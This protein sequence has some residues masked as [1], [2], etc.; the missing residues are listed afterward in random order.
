[1]CS[2]DLSPLA[3]NLWM[4]QANLL[5]ALPAL[6]G[7]AASRP[8]LRG[9]GIGAAA[10]AKMSPGLLVLGLVRERAWGAVLAAG[11]AVVGLGVLTLPLVGPAAQLRFWGE[12]LPGFL[13]GEYHGLHIGIALPGNH[14]LADWFNR[15][16]PGELPTRL[17]D[18]ARLAN[19]LA[20][21]G[22]VGAWALLFRRPAAPAAST[23]PTAA[24]TPTASGCAT[25]AADPDAPLPWA[26]LVVLMVLLPVYTFEHHLAMLLLPLGVLGSR[27]RTPGRALAF[28]LVYLALAAP[29]E[30]ELRAGLREAKFFGMLGLLAL[31]VAW[32]ERPP[33]R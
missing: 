17:S 15:A 14:S 21:L 25:A 30:W 20:G 3:D 13:R 31:A 22:L 10:M 4:G 2:S 12:V 28:G 23:S 5:A 32:R 8:A 1:V 24:A 27:A 16:W 11:L 26:A 33:R 7:V 19:R 9:L 6:L 18:P 29:L